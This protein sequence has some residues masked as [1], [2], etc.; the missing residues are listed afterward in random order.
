MALAPLFFHHPFLI[1][2]YS[3][4]FFSHMKLHL[5]NRL[6]K[7]LLACLA[8]ATPALTSTLA[9]GSALLA[10]FCFS[11]YAADSTP[12]IPDSWNG[13]SNLQEFD[14][15]KNIKVDDKTGNW[16]LGDSSSNNTGKMYFVWTPTAEGNYSLQLMFF[17]D[18]QAIDQWKT[19]N[20]YTGDIYSI[21]YQNVFGSG[22][23]PS[24]NYYWNSSQS[25]SADGVL[26]GN[27][28]LN[29]STSTNQQTGKIT[30]NGSSAGWIHNGQY[31]KDRKLADLKG[32]V[33][34]NQTITDQTY[35]TNGTSYDNSYTS[36]ES[37]SGQ[38]GAAIFLGN[39][40]SIDTVQADFIKNYISADNPHGGA[41]YVGLGSSIET[42]SGNFIGNYTE[43]NNTGKGVGGA[44]LNWGKIGSISGTFIGNYIKTTGSNTSNP[45][46]GVIANGAESISKSVYDGFNGDNKGV[47][48]SIRGYFI[49]NY[50]RNDNQGDVIGATIAN[51]GRI[52]SLE[53]VFIGNYA[54]AQNT[55]NSGVIR[56]YSRKDNTSD[57]RV[58]IIGATAADYEAAVANGTAAKLLD[59]AVINGIFI[60]NYAQGVDG[61]GTGGVMRNNGSING[62]IKGLFIGNHATTTGKMV[63]NN[64]TLQ[65]GTPNLK[66][67]L[68][69][70][71]SIII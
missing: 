23:I 5:P 43:M 21:T 26:T 57:G 70:Y 44:I 2:H 19:N 45:V 61:D 52:G 28:F 66:I 56:N 36:V 35:G 38:G 53:G 30:I 15:T 32:V 27:P 31:E 59:T 29:L 63:M 55:A 39:H 16:T 37:S 13:L 34:Y 7:A 33:F 9:T 51:Y 11:L 65:D 14:T 8:L 17:N 4:P 49:G 46:G 22:I 1:D 18:Q 20:N 3:Y 48:E 64:S 41:V 58:A 60:G 24:A 12:K 40:S 62:A 6:R 71:E 68:G 10:G 42:L 69:T 54:Y 67:E 25:V 50:I 47:I